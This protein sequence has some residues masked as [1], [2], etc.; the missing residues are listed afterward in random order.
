MG[1]FYLIISRLWVFLED[2]YIIEIIQFLTI[3]LN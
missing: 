2:S 1:F 3:R